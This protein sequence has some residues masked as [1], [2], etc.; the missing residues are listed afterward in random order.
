[1]VFIYDK[2]KAFEADFI[3]LMEMQY[4]GILNQVKAGKWTDEETQGIEKAAA[5]VAE[6]YSEKL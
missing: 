1:V 2:V 5:E 3:E 4:R 6:R